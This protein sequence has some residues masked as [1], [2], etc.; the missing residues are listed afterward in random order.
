MKSKLRVAIIGASGIG[1][2][3]A[4]W[5]AGHGC[6]IV[7]LCGTDRTRLA[8]TRDLL[9]EQFGFS[10][11]GYLSVAAMLREEEPDAVCVASPP[12]FHEEHATLSLESG[13]HVLCEKPLTGVS[14]TSSREYSVL[15]GFEIIRSARDLAQ[16][17]R[18]K[19]RLLGTQMQYSFALQPLQKLWDLG[20]E[21]LRAFDAA[22]ETK[23][24][25][26]G[27]EGKEVWL[28]LS[29]HPLSLL[30]KMGAEIEWENLQCRVEPMETTA[31]FFARLPQQQEPCEVRIAVRVEPQRDVPLRTF[32]ANG[33]AVEYAAFR[34]DDGEFQTRLTCGENSIEM[35]D[36][37]N[38]LIGNF[39]AACRG[40]AELFVTGEDGAR[41]V[42]WQW[43]LLDAALS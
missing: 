27:R 30:Q 25:R 21:P 38:V 23:N 31:R 9:C 22:M 16:L 8:S 14:P 26:A 43:K 12:D 39:V 32:S 40:E 24:A 5:F 37:V 4:R 18:D 19:N 13:A 42:E 17:A 1:K 15:T 2:N 34:S 10:G 33:K 29:P 28:D 3:H 36:L 11:A 35:P 41:N 6:E 20:S 7:A